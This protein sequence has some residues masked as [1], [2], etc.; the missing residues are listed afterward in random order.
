VIMAIPYRCYLGKSEV[1]TLSKLFRSGRATAS[2]PRALYLS[3]YFVF[4]QMKAHVEIEIDVVDNDATGQLAS[5]IDR[6][7]LG[8]PRPAHSGRRRDQ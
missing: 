6:F 5:E 7:L 8:P 3:N 2:L 4:L 1:P